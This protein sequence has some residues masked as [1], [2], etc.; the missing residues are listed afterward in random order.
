M[1]VVLRIDSMTRDASKQTVQR[2]SL[3]GFGDE[4]RKRNGVGPGSLESGDVF[5]IN[6]RV[7]VIV[8]P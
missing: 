7:D 5:M 1:F 3:Q 8:Q 4:E 2:Q 6:C